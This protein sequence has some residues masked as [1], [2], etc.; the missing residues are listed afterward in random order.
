MNSYSH[1]LRKDRK[2]RLASRVEEFHMDDVPAVDP[3]VT[4]VDS[5]SR[6]W[7]EHVFWTYVLAES[8][9]HNSKAVP[10]TLD[11]LLGNQDAIGFAIGLHYGQE[12]G[13]KLA[14][15]LRTHINQAVPVL[16]AARDDDK[17]ALDK[18]L[19]DWYG[20]AN[21][22]AMFLTTANPVNWPSSLTDPM[23]RKHLDGTVVYAMD[24]LK[25]DY[26]EAVKHFDE[27]KSHMLMFADE[28]ASGILRQFPITVQ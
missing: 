2:A 12:A 14:S 22:I 23:M 4:T 7:S 1:K 6:L 20:N 15:L 26:S 10:A 18:A 11:R 3:E 28:L 21:E 16:T 5:M 27:A 24:L 17:V 9:F 25:G 19:S 13:D 8:F